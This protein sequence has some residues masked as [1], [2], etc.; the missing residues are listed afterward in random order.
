MV[1][2][3]TRLSSGALNSNLRL[4]SGAGGAANTAVIT[5]ASSNLGINGLA[6]PVYSLDVGGSM[7]V[8][9]FAAAAQTNVTYYPGTTGIIYGRV[10][11]GPTGNLAIDGSTSID[12][13]HNLGTTR[14]MIL[15]SAENSVL[16]PVVQ[17]GVASNASVSARIAVYNPSVTTQPLPTPI[18]FQIVCY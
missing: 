4:V 9:T 3:L 8:G 11:V 10:L 17:Y 1:E 5:A 12:L 16:Q 7:R 18:S 2:S 14:Y 13:T 15:T 6:N